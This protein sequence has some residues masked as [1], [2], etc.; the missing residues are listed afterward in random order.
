MWL[1]KV[2]DPIVGQNQMLDKE[3]FLIF[4]KKVNKDERQRVYME[5]QNKQHSTH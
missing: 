3:E 5:K 2:F 4:Y 1:L